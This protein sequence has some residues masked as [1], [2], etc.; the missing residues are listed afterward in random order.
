MAAAS[1]TRGA[2]PTQGAGEDALGHM[3]AGLAIALQ[4]YE[5]GMGERVASLATEQSALLAKLDAARQVGWFLALVFGFYPV[6][7]T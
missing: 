3:A 2:P 1:R 6:R 5:D 4:C 7:E